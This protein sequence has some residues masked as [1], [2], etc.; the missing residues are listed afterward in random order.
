MHALKDLSDEAFVAGFTNINCARRFT[1]EK[2]QLP[3]R[4]R[5]ETD[6]DIK[7]GKI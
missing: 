6:F 4:K 5:K 7:N 3:R 2:G 1:R